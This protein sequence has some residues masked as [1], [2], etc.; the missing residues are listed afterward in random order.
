MGTRDSSRPIASTL[1]QIVSDVAYLLQTE[2]R[3]ARAEVGEKL[4]VASSGGKYLG[5]A[6]LLFLPALFVLL[7]GA[8]SWLEVAGLP[9]RWGYLLVGGVLMILAAALGLKGVNSLKGSALV[10]DRTIEQLRAD[11][12][13]AKEQIS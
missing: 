1:T 5:I 4:S 13:V 2:I 6:A 11:Y 12:N 7:L 3:L 10:P 9:V 8:V